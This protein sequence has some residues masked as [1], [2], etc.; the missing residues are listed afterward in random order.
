MEQAIKAGVKLYACTQSC[1]LIGM[2]KG[3][4]IEGVKVAGAASVND[5]VLEADGVLYF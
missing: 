2:E 4:L 1:D 3:D 5:L